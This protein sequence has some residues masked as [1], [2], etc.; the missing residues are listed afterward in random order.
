MSDRALPTPE[1]LRQLLRFDPESGKLFWRERPASM[2]DFPAKAALWN[3]RYADKE[4]FKVML[5]CGHMCGMMKGKH[6]LAHRVIWAIV[7]GRWPDG[8]IDHINGVPDD[9]RI[10]NLRDVSHRENSRNVRL[11]SQNKSGHIG[12]HWDAFHG[13]WVARIGIDRVQ[14]RLG[15]FD[16]LEDAVA[17]RRK[18]SL[19]AGFHPNHGRRM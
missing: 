12:V 3:R 16:R 13:K 10:E 18:A 14:R 8:Q 1:E 5:K 9:N 11:T 4:G 19:E 17:A 6:L 15:R 2:F 7:H